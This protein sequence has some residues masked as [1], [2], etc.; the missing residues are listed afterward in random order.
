MPNPS[1]PALSRR[2]FFA[3]LALPFVKRISY[4]NP[5]T[6]THIHETP[7]RCN[8]ENISVAKMIWARRSDGEYFQVV[9][10]ISIEEVDTVSHALG[11]R[12]SFMDEISTPDAAERL[13]WL[14]PKY[15]KATSMLEEFRNCGCTVRG[16]CLYHTLKTQEVS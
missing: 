11:S 9:I 2:A 4:R 1:C 13:G 5:K 8:Q 14:R 16:K 3:L 7:W 10:P 6:W 12:Q 15:Q